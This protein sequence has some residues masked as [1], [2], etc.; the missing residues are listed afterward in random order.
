MAHSGMPEPVR[1]STRPRLRGQ[2]RRRSGDVATPPPLSA[3]AFTVRS[4]CVPTASIARLNLDGHHERQKLPSW[5]LASATMVTVS[6]R[7]LHPTRRPPQVPAPGVSHAT[8]PYGECRGRDGPPHHQVPLGQAH[9]VHRLVHSHRAIRRA[10]CLACPSP[11]PSRPR[12]PVSARGSVARLWCARALP[13]QLEAVVLG[14]KLDVVHRPIVCQPGALSPAAPAPLRL[15]TTWAASGAA[16][17]GGASAPVR[18]CAHAREARYL[19]LAPPRCARVGRQT[20]S[21]GPAQTLGGPMPRAA[22]T[23]RRSVLTTKPAHR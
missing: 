16:P 3:L 9:N 15:W 18:L 19:A 21:R 11:T 4:R 10:G 23:R 7:S 22:P 13:H 20:R 5:S 1:V 6:C 12:L 2:P 8:R 17:Q 14:R